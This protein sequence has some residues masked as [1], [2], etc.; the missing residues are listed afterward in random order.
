MKYLEA[1]AELKRILKGQQT[2]SVSKLKKLLESMSISLKKP[3]VQ[4]TVDET[5][6]TVKRT[7]NGKPTLIEWNG[8]L[9]SLQ[10]MKPKGEGNHDN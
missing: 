10:H 3:P 4:G 6:V 5:I 8:N 2:V 9:Y 1:Q 7:K